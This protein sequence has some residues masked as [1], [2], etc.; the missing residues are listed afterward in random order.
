MHELRRYGVNR[1]RSQ[2]IPRIVEPNLRSKEATMREEKPTCY[3]INPILT[4]ERYQ[5]ELD[6]PFFTD[7]KVIRN[8]W[9]RLRRTPSQKLRAPLS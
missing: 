1:A 5:V 6:S 3:V 8:F 4:L 2:R 9:S 7:S